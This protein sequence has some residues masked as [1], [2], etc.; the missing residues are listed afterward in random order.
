[1]TISTNQLK[2]RF[3][4]VTQKASGRF[5]VLKKLNS[6]SQSQKLAKEMRKKTKKSVRIFDLKIPTYQNRIVSI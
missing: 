2:E 6:K 1:M 4:I 5:A 3:L